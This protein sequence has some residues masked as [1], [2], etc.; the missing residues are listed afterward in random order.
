M[1]RFTYSVT[2][3]ALLLT[4]FA[5]SAAFVTPGELFS[6]LQ[7]DAAKSFALEV[8][9]SSQG[10]YVSV[11]ASGTEQGQSEN[12]R[13]NMKATVDVVKDG[14]KM[15]LKGDILM[16][17]GSMYLKV[18]SLDGSLLNDV[19]SVTAK[20]KQLQWVQLPL[21]ELMLDGA[22]D[23][24]MFSVSSTDPAMADSMFT[25]SSKAGNG[26][27]LYSVS[28]QPDFAAELAL[29]IRGLLNDTE[30]VSDDFFPWRDLAE[31][32][33]FEMTVQT[34]AQNAFVSEN[35]SMSTNSASSY[36]RVS[37]REK[38]LASPLQLT[39]PAGALTLD[40]VAAIFGDWDDVPD[41]G[42]WK[43][44][45]S[46]DMMW[47]GMMS[48]DAIEGSSFDEIDLETSGYIPE[49]NDPML[50]PTQLF[51]LQREGTCPVNKATTR[52]ER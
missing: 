13:L 2:T 36:F 24:T 10:T 23:T 51:M 3:I 12:I 46:E 29:S 22:M 18:S 41:L 47:D 37:G 39:A 44:E 26:G 21:D 31:G 1:R 5:A 35:Y 28:L 42:D 6:S 25:V 50:T 14:M 11:W 33:R 40:E 30:A 19:A 4:P 15:R 32:I 38:V 45:T 20:V 52:Y 7:T 49:C 17:D 43:S 9:A 34:N 48:G 16:V 8:H 27:T